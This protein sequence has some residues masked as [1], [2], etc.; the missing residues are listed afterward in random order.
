MPKPTE[1]PEE[2]R[3]FNK[4]FERLARRWDYSTVFDDFLSCAINYFNRRPE[5]LQDIQRRY[6]DEERQMFGEL[7]VELLKVTQSGIAKHGW[8]DAIGTFYEALASAS[9]K[10]RLGQFFT[11]QPICD[12]M[13]QI[14]PVEGTRNK[15]NDPSCG[16]GR[17]LLATHA[18]F[19]GNYFFAEDLDQMCCKMAA[20]NMMIHGCQGEVININSLSRKEYRRGYR[21]NPLLQATGLPWIEDLPAA[22]S[23]TWAG[24]DSW[25]AKEI[26]PLEDPV[27][28]VIELPDFGELADLPL[29]AATV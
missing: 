14:T 2:L 10:S 16:S 26:A 7:I 3:E 24:F 4:L 19:I 21:I 23:F 1:V 27:P 11:P 20:I 5:T 15:V 13:A 28:E 25:P 17:T 29:F 12:M 6:N 9:K 22:R 18:K 8:Y